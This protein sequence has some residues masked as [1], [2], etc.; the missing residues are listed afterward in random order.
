MKISRIAIKNFR[1]FREFSVDLHDHAVFVGPNNVGKSNL[2][3]ALRLVLDPSL[4]DSARQLRAEDFWDGLPRPIDSAERVEIAVDLTDFE[5]DD[6][7]LA[8]LAEYL[9]QA[10]PMVARLTYIA[11][12]PTASGTSDFYL[13]GGEQE[14]R[15]FGYE[16]RKRLPLDVLHALRD[17]END[18]ASWRRSPLR[19]LVSA[20]WNQVPVETREAIAKAVDDAASTLTGEEAVRAVEKA[21]QSSLA[22]TT[23]SSASADVQLGVT[24]TEPDSL[25][26]IIRLLVDGGRRT[27]A[28]AG[29]GSS[30]V[31]YVTLKLLEIERLVRERERDH[32]FV[33]IEEPEAHLHPHLQRQVYRNFLRLRPHLSSG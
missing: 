15:R 20:A 18:L 26:R 5:E 9:V 14:E 4:P 33:A 6:D 2:L 17:A 10:E 29:L 19:P 7:Q 8:V 22:R 12:P 23:G 1:N 13:F 3:T 32:T 16:L 21:L 11:E 25:I 30:N 31:L 28:D 27:I 24:P